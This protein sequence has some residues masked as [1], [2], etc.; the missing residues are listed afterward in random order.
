VLHGA[1]SSPG[2][3]TGPA[4]I[5]TTPSELG[6]LQ[7][8]DILVSRTATPEWTPSFTVIAGLVTDV[9]GPLSHSSILAREFGVPSVMGVHHAT[10]VIREGQIITLDGG[11]GTIRLHGA[12]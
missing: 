1:A 3:A 12:R 6:R 2:S 10:R 11:R 9:G 5:I 7:P 4:R 8:G